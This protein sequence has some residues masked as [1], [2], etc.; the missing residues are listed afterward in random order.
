MEF[1]SCFRDELGKVVWWCDKHTEQE[2]TDFLNNHPECYLS[3][4]IIS[5]DFK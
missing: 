5:D 2:N 4:I 1:R 3:S